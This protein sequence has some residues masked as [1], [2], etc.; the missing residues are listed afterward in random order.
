MPAEPAEAAPVS[1]PPVTYRTEP[2][3]RRD[4]AAGPWPT[5]DRPR[6]TPAHTPPAE[7]A[8]VEIHIGRIEIRSAATPPPAARKRDEHPRVMPLDEYLRRR[9]GGS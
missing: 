3:L 5:A 7:P 2:S 4:A 1:G 9:R 8:A 6:R